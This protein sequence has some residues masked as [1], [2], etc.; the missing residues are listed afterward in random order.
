MTPEGSQNLMNN[1]VND[2]VRPEIE[3]RSREG[4][5]IAE[6]IWA[7]QVIFDEGVPA[8]RIRLNR[9]VRLVAQAADS[10]EFQ[11][12]VELRDS[13]V[14]QFSSVALPQHEA[15]IR[16]MSLCQIGVTSHWR[17]F[18]SLGERTAPNELAQGDATFNAG[19]EEPVLSEWEALYAEH[20]RVAEAVLAVNSPTPESPI[21]T[22]MA[23]ALQRS[24]H[25]LQAYVHLLSSKNLTAASALIRMQLD[26]VMRVNACFLVATPLEVWEAL[27]SGEPWNR[28]RSKKNKPLSDGY[29]HEQLSA[30]Y[31]WASEVYK[32]M[33]GYVH[34]SRP[35]L[36]STVEGEEFLGMV[37][38]QGPAAARVTERDLA[39]NAQL[40][41]KVTRALLS[42]CEEYAINRSAP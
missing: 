7:A 35:H 9:E 39:E 33:S 18:F 3:R 17:I 4:N 14:H 21:E 23:V 42:L 38:H 19:Y 28:V 22:V 37:I 30:K 36:E 24:R 8:P 16:H 1:I 29:L 2:F 40:F 11:D 25:L 12:Y 15:T 31:E 32:Q 26:S 10:S 5:P 34:L 41:I 6:E 27:K 20:D 13:G